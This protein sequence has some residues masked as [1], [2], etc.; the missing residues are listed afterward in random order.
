MLSKNVINEVMKEWAWRVS[1]GIPDITKTEDLKLLREVLIDDFNLS[2]YD[3]DKIIEALSK[4]KLINLSK[5][6]MAMNKTIQLN[7]FFKNATSEAAAKIKP[8]LTILDNEQKALESKNKDLKPTDSKYKVGAQCTEFLTALGSVSN[9]TSLANNFPSTGIMKD[10]FNLGDPLGKGELW[11]S[12][13]V[14]GV[15]ISGTGKS[16]DVTHGSKKYEVKEQKQGDNTP[17]RLGVHAAL[18]QFDWWS[19]MK[20]INNVCAELNQMDL[21]KMAKSLGASSAGVIK[22]I[23]GVLKYSGAVDKGAFSERDYAPSYHKFLEEA[24]KFGMSDVQGYTQV[25]LTGPNRAEIIRSIVPIDQTAIKTKGSLTVELLENSP[26]DAADFVKT[27][28]NSL[29]YVRADDPVVALKQGQQD[30][31]D[32]IAQHYAGV[33]FMIFRSNTIDFV[34]PKNFYYKTSTQGKV[35]IT[36][37]SAKSHI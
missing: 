26:E 4:G 30:S 32:V 8:T 16:Y 9:V 28:L 17:V 10:I 3:A 22:G 27:K 33:T 36:Y 13:Y 7:A 5:A 6:A 11:T 14:Q 29:K 12:V 15:K 24:K 35:K 1:T 31:I 23:K 21:K 18:T 25:Q 20:K 19:E 37:G 2:L 34:N